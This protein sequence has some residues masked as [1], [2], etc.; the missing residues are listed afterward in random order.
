MAFPAIRCRDKDRAA[1][2]RGIRGDAVCENRSS[3]AVRAP[4][5][6]V[7]RGGKDGRHQFIQLQT[8]LKYSPINKSH[9]SK[10]DVNALET[11]DA[12][13]TRRSPCP[14]PLRMSSCPHRLHSRHLLSEF[15]LGV[16]SYDGRN[17]LRL[18]EI[19][20]QIIKNSEPTVRES[21]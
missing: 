6:P 21:Q 1:R 9:F 17:W 10:L 19:D 15:Q 13:E 11:A 18:R 8:I 14:L 5:R 20:F 12:K 4:S 7:C 16:H 2:V 3:Q